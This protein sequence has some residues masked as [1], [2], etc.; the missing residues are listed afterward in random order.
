M[1]GFD[2]RIG[3]DSV[4]MPHG[5]LPNQTRAN[6]SGAMIAGAISLDFALLGNHYCRQSRAGTYSYADDVVTRTPANAIIQMEIVCI[7]ISS[8]ARFDVTLHSPTPSQTGGSWAAPRR[9]ASIEQN[10]S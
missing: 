8:P 9:G 4:D 2:W 1:T 7:K 5:Q 3:G 6:I 10:Y